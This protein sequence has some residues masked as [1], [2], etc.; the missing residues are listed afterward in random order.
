MKN[1]KVRTDHPG[2]TQRQIRLD[3]FSAKM[4]G[5]TPECCCWLA[6]QSPAA[7]V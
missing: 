6:E 1:E 5:I 3:S 2:D 7:A 4:Q